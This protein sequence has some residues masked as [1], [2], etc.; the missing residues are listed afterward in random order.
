MRY[1]FRC[2]FVNILKITEINTFHKLKLP[3][4]NV[5]SGRYVAPGRRP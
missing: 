4:S 2:T 3:P 5:P 1:V